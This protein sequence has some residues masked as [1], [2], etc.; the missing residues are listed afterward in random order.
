MT[1]DATAGKHTYII[2]GE[3]FSSLEEFY[4]EV[5]RVVVPGLTWG[6]NLDAFN[7]VVRG[8]GTPAEGF[9]L[10]WNEETVRQ[11]GKMMTRSHPLGLPALEKRLAEAEQ[12]Q[13]ET[14]FDWLVAII[15]DARDVQLILD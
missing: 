2:D 13:G 1:T 10:V 15:R 12:H 6:K 11:L 5:S 7:D 9:T 14:V 3:N 8:Y 4:N